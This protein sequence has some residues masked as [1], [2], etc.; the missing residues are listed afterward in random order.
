MTRPDFQGGS[1][2]LGYW[3]LYGRLLNE[4]PWGAL[5]LKLDVL[6]PNPGTQD[7]WASIHTK[8]EGGSF[9]NA[10]DQNGKLSAFRVTQMY[11]KAGNIL[12]DRVTWQLG[13]LDTYFGDLGLYDVKPAQIFFET[14]GLSARYNADRF[15][16]LVGVG[17]SGYFMRQSR[18]NTLFTAGG[19]LR[20][21]LGDHFEIGAGG[22]GY[23][24][25]SIQGNQFSPYSTRLPGVG[26]EE[27]LRHETMQRYFELNPM[28]S[29]ELLPVPE[30][31]SAGSYK[32]VGYIG[33]GKLGPLRWNNL[34]VNYLRR[35]PDA[36][37]DEVFEGR[38][39]PIYVTDMTDE[40]YEVNGGNE[41]QLS[42]I[43]DRLDL[44]WGV[45]FGY[46]FNKDNALKPGDDNRLFYSTVLRLQ[47]Y[48]SQTVHFLTESSLAREQSGLLCGP[49]RIPCN[50]YREHSDS[51]FA[52]SAGVPDSRGFEFGD[53]NARN[54]WQLKTGFVLNPTGMGIYTRPSLRVLY[55]LQYSNQQAA[56]GN[57]FVE[58]QSQYNLFKT[59]ELHWHHMVAIE[60]EAWF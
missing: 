28:A 6:K 15:E 53:S 56:F 44:V 54:T 4:G 10:D 1:S 34:Y 16:L 51:V 18:Y 21:R 26:Y 37:Y 55:G 14:I 58:N 5:E 17:D 27:Y 57:G 43:P 9:S 59:P 25:P 60:A 36:P 30:A 3:N 52:N 2:K 48:L 12:F 23:Y 8:I 39:Y 11:V 46:H 13:T 49:G 32:L 50:Q 42:I 19:T 24:E 38:T 22:V 31:S 45:L 40:R 29:R 7:V 35:H 20:V 41:M 33:F 47:L